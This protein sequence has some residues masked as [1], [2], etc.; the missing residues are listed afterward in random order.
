MASLRA[1]HGADFDRAFVEHEV[2]FHSRE[3]TTSLRRPGGRAERNCRLLQTPAPET[4]AGV[5]R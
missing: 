2:A 3:R 4:G 1:K 5:F